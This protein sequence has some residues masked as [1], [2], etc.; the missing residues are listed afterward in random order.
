MGIQLFFSSNGIKLFPYRV[1]CLGFYLLMGYQNLASSPSS[2]E[3][4]LCPVFI[5]SFSISH[6]LLF[7]SL[8]LAPSLH[9][10]FCECRKIPIF[11]LS[12]IY[13]VGRVIEWEGGENK[14]VGDISRGEIKVHCIVWGS[15]TR[16]YE[17]IH[18][19]PLIFACA[20]A[21]THTNAHTLF[22]VCIGSAWLINSRFLLGADMPIL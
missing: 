9:L 6:S 4:S 22:S 5:S 12:S 11:S 14:T 8:S 19:F 16:H 10:P 18:I 1:I 17:N 2:F 3:S 21:H 7:I 15:Q 20:C 13:W